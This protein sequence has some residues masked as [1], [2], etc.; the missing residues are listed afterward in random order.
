MPFPASNHIPPRQ[1]PVKQQTLR[2][3]LAPQPLSYANPLLDPVNDVQQSRSSAHAGLHHEFGRSTRGSLAYRGEYVTYFEV[4]KNDALPPSFLVHGPELTAERDL[5]PLTSVGALYTYRT[6]T[7]DSVKA[8]Q[9]V[10]RDWQGHVAELSVRSTPTEWLGVRARGGFKSITYT[11]NKEAKTRLVADGD[12]V[13][14]GDVGRVELQLSHDLTQDI[15]GNAATLTRV[16]LGA[17][18]TPSAPWTA[19]VGASYGQHDLIFPAAATTT[20]KTHQ[21]FVE[22]TAG[23]SY[24]IS[25]GILTLGVM[26]HEST[27]KIDAVSTQAKVVVNRATLSLGGKF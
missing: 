15:L 14:G 18:Y 22:G 1:H 11:D 21:G 27:T 16:G 19:R 2:Q 8:G 9:L 23:A 4:H 13:A 10:P 20:L 7:Y 26:H 6:E 17:D 3:I 24:R 12:A 25:P 5:G